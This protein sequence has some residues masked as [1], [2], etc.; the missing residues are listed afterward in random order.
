MH[1]CHM[2]M[3]STLLVATPRHHC[4]YALASQY[5]S[6]IIMALSCIP[7]DPSDARHWG[8]ANM[9]AFSFR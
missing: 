5:I 9:M 4:P 6:L 2:K 7:N 8:W 1:V 3:K